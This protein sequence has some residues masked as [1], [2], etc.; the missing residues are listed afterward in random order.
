[1][2][3]G[4]RKRTKSLIRVLM[5]FTVVVILLAIWYYNRSNQS[6]DPR[7]VPARKLYEGYNALARENDFASV[8]HLLDTIESIYNKYPHYRQSFETGVIENN[9][10]AVYLTLGIYYD[11]LSSVYHY[12]GPDSLISLGEL[13]V[14]NSIN[15]Y[16]RWERNF[17]GRNEQEIR[18]LIRDSFIKGLS[19]QS[20]EELESYLDS[21][22]EE[23]MSASQETPR[24][25]S[26]S[27]TNLGIVYRYREDYQGAVDCYKKAM[28]LWEDNL[29]AENNLNLLLGRP[30][31]KRSFIKKLFPESKE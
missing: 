9:R 2:S 26:V 19:G 12:L 3:T 5:T 25:L 24:R 21:R 31:K 11:S 27:Y 10:A 13:S 16:E 1:V 22:V 8:I 30:M 15:I 28:D 17:S 7:V 4:N 20:D 23:I 29:T 18:E 6:V 14:K